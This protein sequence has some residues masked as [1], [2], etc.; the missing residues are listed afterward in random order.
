MWL[1]SCPRSANPSHA[2]AKTFG[3]DPW[4]HE[5]TRRCG[6][7]TSPIPRGGSPRMW[8]QWRRH[9][10]K[11]HDLRIL[12]CP[13]LIAGGATSANR[14]SLTSPSPGKKLRGT[15]PLPPDLLRD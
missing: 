6:S 4:N 10:N 11:V 15:F 1:S 5:V 13:V 12:A 7:S 14:S 8:W 2:D 3:G 9:D